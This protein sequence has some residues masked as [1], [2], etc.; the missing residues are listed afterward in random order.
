MDDW[1]DMLVDR[2]LELQLFEGRFQPEALQN[3]RHMTYHIHYRNKE[4]YHSTTPRRSDSNLILLTLHLEKLHV[5]CAK[6]IILQCTYS[7]SKRR[8]RCRPLTMCRYIYSSSTHLAE[9]KIMQS[10]LIPLT[11]PLENERVC[12]QRQ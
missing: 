7:H 9:S 4:N 6:L 12:D 5:H 10:V 3:I 1:D 2:G 8:P 11:S